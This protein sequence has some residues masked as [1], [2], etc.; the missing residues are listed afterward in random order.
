MSVFVVESGGDPPDQR[1]PLETASPS[2]VQAS[3]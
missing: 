1:I 3:P 2:T